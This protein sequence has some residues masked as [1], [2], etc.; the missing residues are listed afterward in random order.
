MRVRLRNDQLARHLAQSRRSQNAWAQRLKV[1]RGHLSDLVKGKHPYPSA[2]TR[3]K[4]LEG[5]D[6]SF[7]DLFEIEES[8]THSSDAPETT[9]GVSGRGAGDSNQRPPWRMADQGAFF[10]HIALT[11]LL[12]AICTGAWLIIDQVFIAP[13]PFPESGQLVVIRQ[14]NGDQVGPSPSWPNFNDIRQ[15]TRMLDSVAAYVS[16]A[17]LPVRDASGTYAA[18]GAIVTEDFF[19]TMG[20]PALLG[21]L[22]GAESDRDGVMPVAIGSRLWRRRYDSDPSAVGSSIEIHGVEGVVIAVLPE[23]FSFPGRSQVW[24]PHSFLPAGEGTRTAHNFE[25]V[26]ARLKKGV[27]LPQAVL[28]LEAIGQRLT[29]LHGDLEEG[30]GL[31]AA[32]LRSY[33]TARFRERAWLI[34]AS[35]LLLWILAFQTAAHVSAHSRL[36]RTAWRRLGHKEWACS[37]AGLLLGWPVGLWLAQVLESALSIPWLNRSLA[38]S[39]GLSMAGSVAIAALAA[40]TLGLLAAL[41]AGRLVKSA[42]KERGTGFLSLTFAATLVPLLIL[43]GAAFRFG[44]EWHSLAN[45]DLGFD[46]GGL[47]EV[48]LNL[49]GRTGPDW[50]ALDEEVADF[51]QRLLKKVERLQEIEGAAL[52]FSPPLSDAYKIDSLMLRADRPEGKEIRGNFDFR[53]VSAGYFRLLNLPLLAGRGFR[54]GDDLASQRVAVVN[55]SLAEQFWGSSRDAVGGQVLIPGQA[56]DS[57]SNPL[58]LHIVGVVADIRQRALSR[59]PRPALYVPYQQYPVRAPYMR[60]LAKSSQAPQPAAALIWQ[61]IHEV[62]SEIPSSQPRILQDLIEAR[63]Q[64]VRFEAAISMWA[65]GLGL[66]LFGAVVWSRRLPA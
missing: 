49:P 9:G 16:S 38:E 2:T 52:A 32:S 21:R 14:T 11:V 15:R 27:S 34:A 54:S 8:A 64:P 66:L 42:S 4:L 7:E 65:A 55:E 45:T 36:S 10:F 12:V 5:L 33:L 17:N 61:V 18:A 6:L 63:I 48:Q 1:S 31:A 62:N 43:L 58:P 46:P 19:K 53:L 50:P 20:V 29:A 40:L 47:I 51:H 25:E 35:A 22:P 3:N 24:A 59:T 57:A 37:A 56:Y 13:L 30:F 23:G 60:L 26:I 28:E 41:Y 39:S 44:S